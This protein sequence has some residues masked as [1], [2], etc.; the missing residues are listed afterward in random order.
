M[1]LKKLKT[2]FNDL[3]TSP[4]PE[5][6]V[7][8]RLIP[9]SES[10][11]NSVG[12]L[13]NAGVKAGQ[14]GFVG[15][16]WSVTPRTLYYSNGTAWVDT[17]LTKADQEKKL[18]QHGMI[19]RIYRVDNT[20]LCE[21]SHFPYSL[22]TLLSS[23]SGNVDLSDYNGHKITMTLTGATTIT[24]LPDYCSLSVVLNGEELNLPRILHVFN[25][26]ST[27]TLGGFTLNSGG[28]GGIDNASLEILP[29]V[30]LGTVD[31]LDLLVNMGE[32]MAYSDLG[33]VL[34]LD[35][36]YIRNQIPN[37]EYLPYHIYYIKVSVEVGIIDP[38]H[39]VIKYQNTEAPLLKNVEFRIMFINNESVN[40]N[41]TITF[42]QDNPLPDLFNIPTLTIGESS[43][44][45]FSDVYSIL[46]LS[47]NFTSIYLEDYLDWN[48]AFLI[49]VIFDGVGMC[50]THIQPLSEY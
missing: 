44:N 37:G 39:I 10:I 30:I 45:P 38:A 34:D 40:G 42:E 31:T 49:R 22:T 24:V 2:Q 5:Q 28:S 11:F 21:L 19:K 48:T 41:M 8:Y 9:G 25:Q 20:G 12:A 16:D 13:G 29:N 17:E 32:H 3:V 7:I 15:A 35:E 46:N 6:N 4:I 23:V 18:Y 50:H 1:S 27:A 33:G 36:A 14:Y 43:G 26:D 47:N